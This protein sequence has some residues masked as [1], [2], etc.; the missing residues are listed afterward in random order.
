MVLRAPYGKLVV[1]AG[2]WSKAFD[3]LRYEWSEAP[4]FVLLIVVVTAFVGP[5]VIF[6]VWNTVVGWF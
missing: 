6:G 3:A 5:M 4:W 1:M 2:K